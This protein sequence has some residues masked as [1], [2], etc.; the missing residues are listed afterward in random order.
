MAK[1]EN[2]KVADKALPK[3]DKKPGP[4]T[5]DAPF[6]DIIDAILGADAEAVREH[7]LR[8]RRKA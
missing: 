3:P 5:V 7:R 6:D 2:G 1:T 8:R 4:E